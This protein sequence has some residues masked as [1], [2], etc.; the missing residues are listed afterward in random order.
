MSAVPSPCISICQMDMQNRFCTGCL[1]TPEEI[2]A[3]RTAP[4][5][6]RQEI[7]DKVAARRKEET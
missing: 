7:L 5:S 3:W 1:R 2:G 4:D 6:V